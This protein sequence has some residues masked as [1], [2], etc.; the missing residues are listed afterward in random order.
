M[1][2]L[3][4]SLKVNVS[5]ACF[6]DIMSMVEEFISEV[7]KDWLNR[8]EDHA[9]TEKNRI[10]GK[11][12]LTITPDNPEGDPNLAKERQASIERIK[13]FRKRKAEYLEK[14]AREERN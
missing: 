13:K 8:K 3:F 6:E 9:N 2:N 1:E 11:H 14:K 4:E 10:I 5:E 12:G 7:S